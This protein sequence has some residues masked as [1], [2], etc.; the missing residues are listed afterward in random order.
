MK[1]IGQAPALTRPLWDK[2]IEFIKVN[3]SVRTAV[4]LAFTG[5]FGLRCSE[6]L[7]LKVED[8][9]FRG[10][11]PRI[12]I[13][14]DTPGAKKSPGDVYVW[15]RRLE[16]LKNLFKEGESATVIKGHKHGKLGA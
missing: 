6:A 7:A 5:N 3:C 16:W 9:S 11:I 12:T 4:I 1:R 13:T 8:I 2:W 15:A 14:G 10:E